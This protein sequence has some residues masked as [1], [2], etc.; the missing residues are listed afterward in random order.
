MTPEARATYIVGC[1][2]NAAD[3]H[4]TEAERLLAEHD[5]HRRTEVLTK[6][7]DFVS[8]SGTGFPVA[9][10]NGVGWAVRTLRRLAEETTTGGAIP[11]PA[12]ES[13]QPPPDFF[14]PDRTYAHANYR[15]QCLY[16]VTHPVTGEV[17]AWGW[18]GKATA[19]GRRHMSFG[20]GQW[21]A[22]AWD[23]ITDGRVQCDHGRY[24][25]HSCPSCQIGTRT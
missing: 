13:T 25:P 4:V 22:R 7:A 10:R 16:H 20:R 9:V 6:A 5:A 19:E 12:G 8:A 3:I 21:E 14:Q 15:F 17:Q 24:L 11:A 18:F 2:R 23:D 1:I